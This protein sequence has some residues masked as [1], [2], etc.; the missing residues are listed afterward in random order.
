VHLLGT[1]FAPHQRLH[2][3]GSHWHR[4]VSGSAQNVESVS[5]DVVKLCVTV[6]TGHA[7]KFEQWRAR[8]KEKGK[9][10]IDSGI[11]IE[12]HFG[13]HGVGSSPP[14]NKESV[15][16]IANSTASLFCQELSPRNS[17]FCYSREQ[18]GLVET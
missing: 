10:V 1:Q 6:N 2:C 5:H 3:A 7:K 13:R 14:R 17:G 15:A 8:S 16:R 4:H 9:R 11:N 18:K 12:N